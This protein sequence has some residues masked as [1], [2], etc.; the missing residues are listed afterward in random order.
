MEDGAVL[1]GT[2]AGRPQ[3]L[4]Q[5]TKD[6]APAVKENPHWDT[7]AAIDEIAERLNI[8]SDAARLFAALFT[9]RALDL[10]AMTDEIEQTPSDSAAG[11]W[12]D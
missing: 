4:V 10:F 2:G 6:M 9:K 12:D 5:V 7:A 8:D 3:A 11:E 1:H